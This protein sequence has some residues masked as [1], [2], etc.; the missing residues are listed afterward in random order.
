VVKREAKAAIA[1]VAEYLRR[2]LRQVLPGQRAAPWMRFAGFIE[3]GNCQSS[4][5]IDHVVYGS[6]SLAW[7][8]AEKRNENH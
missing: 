6:K 3:S 2:T 5:T 8:D 4:Q 1:S 7:Q